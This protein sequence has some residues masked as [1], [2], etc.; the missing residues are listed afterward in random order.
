M[1]PDIADTR[2]TLEYGQSH[3]LARQFLPWSLGAIAVGLFLLMSLD[4][5]DPDTEAKLLGGMAIAIGIA[6]LGVV[7]YRRTQ[8][9]V[10]GLVVSEQGILFRPISEKIL[11]W[12]EIRD[13]TRDKVSAPRDFFS[14]KVVRLEVSPSF[15]ERYTSGTWH[16]SVTGESGDPSAIYLAYYLDVPHEELYLAVRKRW[17]AFSH[18]AAGALPEL[19]LI[20]PAAVLPAD[21]GRP[22]AGSATVGARRGGG[23]MQ[24]ATS[25]ESLRALVALLHGS[26]PGQLLGTVAALAAIVA[27]VSNMMGVW[28]TPQQDRGRAE[29][30]KW[31]NWQEKLDADMKKLDAE[32]KRIKDM[33]DREFKCMD[34]YWAR[35]ENGQRGDP[36]CMKKK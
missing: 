9:S 19:D 1:R 21:D 31:K 13:V 4:G 15:Y 23:V 7:I 20:Y 34:E 22:L 36:E 3:D 17:L 16:E 30:A 28:S 10:P 27:I 18:H 35:H 11:P 25:F 24:R 32:Q 5:N 2:S 33:W 12:D 6:F 29:A 14:T 8:P 26:S